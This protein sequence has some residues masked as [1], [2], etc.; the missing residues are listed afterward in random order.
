MHLR[1]LE[2]RSRP[3]DP[4]A[5]GSRPGAW[6]LHFAGTPASALRHPRKRPTISSSRAFE[7][8]G[9]STIFSRRMISLIS[10]PSAT[11]RRAGSMKRLAGGRLRDVLGAGAAHDL[12]LHV[13]Y[14]RLEQARSA[15]RPD[16]PGRACPA[17]PSCCGCAS[18]G[19]ARAACWRPRP[20]AA[21]AR[22][23]RSHRM[24]R[25]TPRRAP[26]ATGSSTLFTSTLNTACLPASSVAR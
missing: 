26:G 12:D 19:R 4:R 23:P 2:D 1:V 24:R 3:P 15:R 20:R 11:R 22:R 17:P 16:S 5:P 13:P 18:S 10:R 7:R 25:K 14:L 8:A 21:S 6:R 9:S